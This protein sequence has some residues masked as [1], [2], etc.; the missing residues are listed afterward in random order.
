MVQRCEDPAAQNYPRYGG[1][2]IIVCDRWLGPH[3]FERFL[4]DL[5]PKP[6]GTSLDRINNNWI[7]EPGNVRWATP[8]EQAANKRPERPEHARRRIRAMNRT[9]RLRAKQRHAGHDWFVYRGRLRCR[10]CHNAYMRS[11][12]ARKT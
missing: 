5:G 3:G 11:H 9:R 4:A 8:Q 7:Y 12:R 6:P 10:T 2:G 1:R